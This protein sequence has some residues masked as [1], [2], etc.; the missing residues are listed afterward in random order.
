MTYT[1]AIQIRVSK[2]Q[3]SKI[4]LDAGLLGF[5]SV[6]NYIR[7]LALASD[8][9]LERKVDEI[10]QILTGKKPCKNVKVN[11]YPPFIN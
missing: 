8:L 11:K 5:S 6:S 1:R 9:V 10:H 7:Y 3:H 4:K 2:S